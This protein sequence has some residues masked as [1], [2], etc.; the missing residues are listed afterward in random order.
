MKNIKFLIISIIITV[1]AACSKPPIDITGSWS[2]TVKD[3]TT[4]MVLS[5]PD[6]VVISAYTEAGKAAGMVMSFEGKYSQTGSNSGVIKVDVLGQKSEATFIVEDGKM[7][8][9]TQQNEK[10]I[11]SKKQ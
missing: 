11:Y 10:E 8:I 3:T 7:I 2:R 9:T 5:N 1:F 4:D 6:K